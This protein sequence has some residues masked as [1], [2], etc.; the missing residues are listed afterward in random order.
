MEHLLETLVSSAKY[1]GF[2]FQISL[3]LLGSICDRTIQKAQSHGAIK[4]V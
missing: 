1:E 3:H 4:M 2:L